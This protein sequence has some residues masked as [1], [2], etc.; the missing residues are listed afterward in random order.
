MTE[1]IPFWVPLFRISYQY[2]KRIV[3]NGAALGNVLKIQHVHDQ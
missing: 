1:N 3:L 2:K